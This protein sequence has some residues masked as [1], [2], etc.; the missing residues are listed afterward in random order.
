MSVLLAI[1][2]ACQALAVL[3]VFIVLGR[4][5][6][7]LIGAAFIGVAVVFHGL[8]EVVQIWTPFN[9]YDPYATQEMVDKWVWVAGVAILVL[10]LSYLV[11]LRQVPNREAN[12]RLPSSRLP[13]F[14]WR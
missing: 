5:A 10:T 2:L 11:T 9:L 8:T 14:D 3:L 12:S 4:G 1:G 7:G 6:I 13:T